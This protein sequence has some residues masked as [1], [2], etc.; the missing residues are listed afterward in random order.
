MSNFK[1]PRSGRNPRACP[2]RNEPPRSGQAKLVKFASATALAVGIYKI[3]SDARRHPE[4][5]EGSPSNVGDSHAR[6]TLRLRSA[7]GDTSCRL[8]LALQQ[9]NVSHPSH[10][11]DHSLQLHDREC[12]GGKGRGKGCGFRDRI[13][14]LRLVCGQRVEYFQFFIS[15]GKVFPRVKCGL[16]VREVQRRENIVR[17]GDRYCSFRSEERRVGKECR[18]RWSPYH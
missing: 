3:K 4:R 1:R 17:R 15:I 7:Q 10:I 5:S 6:E 16:D 9:F 2:W 13:D 14:V 12:A 11:L 8:H 18:S